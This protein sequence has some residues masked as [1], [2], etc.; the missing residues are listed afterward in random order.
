MLYQQVRQEPAQWILIQDITGTNHCTAMSEL[1]EWMGLVQV[2]RLAKS[3]NQHSD[4][5]TKIHSERQSRRQSPSPHWLMKPQ[6]RELPMNWTP[7]LGHLQSLW[8]QKQSRA[9]PQ[10]TVELPIVHPQP[11]DPSSMSPS[12]RAHLQGSEKRSTHLPR[13][14]GDLLQASQGTLAS[15]PLK[16]C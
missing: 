10:A 14:S 6:V 13:H 11:N 9:Q 15:V 12:D 3:R 2:K 5:P 1:Q 8:R 16:E 7:I 4:D